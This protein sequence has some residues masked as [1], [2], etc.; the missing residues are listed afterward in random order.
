M[1]GD[2]RVAV[3]GMVW[4]T[5]KQN[6]KEHPCERC[7]S[8]TTCDCPVDVPYSPGYICVVCGKAY[9]SGHLYTCSQACHEKFAEV[10]CKMFG[11]YKKVV[12]AE[13]GKAYRVPTIHIIEGGLRHA[14]LVKYP[15]WKP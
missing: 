7:G 2:A 14:D 8:T 4:V 9:V 3:P 13:T 6:S 5:G 10:L 11:P 12:D 1:S 15:E